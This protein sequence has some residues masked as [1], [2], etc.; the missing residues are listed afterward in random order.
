MTNTGVCSGAESATDG[1]PSSE[2]R[3]FVSAGAIVDGVRVQMI[4]NVCIDVTL[5]G[6]EFLM[7]I[8]ALALRRRR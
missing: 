5:K 7:L 1:R 2:L 8:A 4:R 3:V 6:E